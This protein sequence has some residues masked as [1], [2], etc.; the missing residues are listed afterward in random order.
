[1]L[2]WIDVQVQEQRRQDLLRD[3]ER[4]RLIHTLKTA[5]PRSAHFYSPA[6]ANLGRRLVV[7]GSR[8]QA[9]YGPVVEVSEG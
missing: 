6:L 2:N 1:M 5:R 7:W 9:H 8:L 3:I 4:R